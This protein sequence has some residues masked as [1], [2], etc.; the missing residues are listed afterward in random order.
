MDGR[1]EDKKIACYRC[2]NEGHKAE[3][4]RARLQD[5]RKCG[6]IGHGAHVSRSKKQNPSSMQRSK[7]SKWNLKTNG[8]KQKKF[9]IQAVSEDWLSEESTYEDYFEPVFRLNSKDGSIQVVINGQNVK[10]VVD[11][12]S[13]QNIISSHVYR[14]LFQSYELQKTKKMFT[15]YGQQKP[16]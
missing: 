9:K 15:A 12:G 13:K 16:L 6:K 3:S 5:C 7:Q 4:C 8:K 11:R 1:F 14:A 10:M 2:G